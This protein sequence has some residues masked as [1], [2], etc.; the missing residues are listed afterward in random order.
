MWDLILVLDLQDVAEFTGLNPA[1]DG[2]SG[3]TGDFC[4]LADPQIIF[5]DSNGANDAVDTIKTCRDA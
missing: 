1:Q 4:D 3:F 5:H 2:S